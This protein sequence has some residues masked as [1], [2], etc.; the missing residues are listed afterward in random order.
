MY[1]PERKPLFRKNV[2]KTNPYSVAAM[3]GI[4]LVMVI[5]LR[6]LNQ[7]EITPMFMPTPTPTRTLDSFAGE[8]EAYF[9]AGDLDKSIEAYYQAVALDPGNAELQAELARILVYSSTLLTIDQDRIERLKEALTTINNAV[10]ITPEDS[11]VHAIK[12][13]VL[14]WLAGNS[15]TQTE[16]ETLLNQAE[17]EAIYAI[18][19][20]NQNMLAL[21]YYSEILVDQQ[22]WIQAEQNI[23]EAV[24][25]A[26]ELMDVRRINGYVQESL[27]N[28]SLA[29]SEYKEAIHINPN[30]TFIYLRIGAN[31]R[32]LTQFD[33]ALE[34]FDKAAIINEQL[35][36][37]DSIPYFSIAT[38]YTQMGEF[39]SA[40]LNARKGLNYD[41]D[42]AD[43]FGRLGIVYHRSRNYEGAILA[44]KCSVRGC[45]AEE[46]CEVRQCNP[47]TDTMVAVEGL[48]LTA[49]TVDYYLTYGAVLSGM[50][51]TS[52]GFCEEG[53]DILKMVKADYS[54]DPI[55]MQ[56]VVESETICNSYGYY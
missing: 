12:A 35:G 42:N 9:G 51:R 18:Q 8:G 41:P 52:N 27:G 26:P 21:A 28:Y 4:I 31:Y 2:K 20:D 13:F 10:E 56:N 45:T 11:M 17:Q 22:K 37:R 53:M 43:A 3:L 19:M 33:S 23:N 50:H 49:G 24:V 48:P 32:K 54:G 5:V 1:I 36:V 47:E 6:S 39:F 46:S 38:T 30:L 34:Y 40:G 55:I 25:Q 15:L 14:D 7:G 44:F 29:I 16:N